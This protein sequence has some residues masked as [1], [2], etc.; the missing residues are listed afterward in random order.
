MPIV[1]MICLACNKSFEIE[2]WRV[3][4]GR[5]KF[6]SKKCKYEYKKITTEKVIKI[7][8]ICKNQFTKLPNEVKSTKCIYCSAKCYHESCRKIINI[9][10]KVCEKEFTSTPS[11][12]RKYCSDECSRIAHIGR[13]HSKEVKE[14]L[15]QVNIG[16]KL[17]EEHKKKLSDAKLGD[18]SRTWL[19]GVSFIPY[20]PKFNR[21][22][23]EEIR[24]KFNRRCYHC[25]K[26][27]KNDTCKLH[28]HHVDYNKNTL[29]NGKTWPL[30]PLCRKCHLKTNHNRYYWFNL[31]IN[32]WAVNPEINFNV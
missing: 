3:R 16:K 7:C 24:N 17:T 30:L 22:L 21:R 26:D 4:N 25:N 18:K 10:C 9:T 11:H 29:C 20:C 15:R 8:P 1:T 5:R 2:S 31:L 14:R 27:E 19:G 32:Y 13:K 23:K 12:N 6:C 28:I